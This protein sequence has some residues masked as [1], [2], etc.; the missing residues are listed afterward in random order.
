MQSR[1]LSS[2]ASKTTIKLSRIP[3]RG[4]LEVG[5]GGHALALLQK[6]THVSE[7]QDAFQVT[8]TLCRP[9]ADVVVIAVNVGLP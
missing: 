6:R 2:K 7:P 3:Y 1:R 8:V 9:P 4:R 5:A